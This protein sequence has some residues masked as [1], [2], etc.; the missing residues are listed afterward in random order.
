MVS[1]HGF[2]TRPE[3]AQHK[4][5]IENSK[6]THVD[7]VLKILLHTEKRSANIF[8][9]NM[10]D[11]RMSVE[12]ELHPKNTL[13]GEEVNLRDGE[14]QVNLNEIQDNKCELQRTV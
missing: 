4:T 7:F 10:V 1:E 11:A 14:I 2:N 3:Q 13:N 9:G 6:L 12:E 8:A 5:A